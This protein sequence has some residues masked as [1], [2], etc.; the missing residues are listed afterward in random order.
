MSSIANETLGNV[1]T[2]K[3]FAGEDMA[4]E[5]FEISNKGVENI[6]KNMGLYMAIMFIVFTLLEHV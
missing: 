2:V 3:C 1:K 5:N 4:S 6:G